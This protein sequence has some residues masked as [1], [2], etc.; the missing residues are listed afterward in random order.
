[1][2]VP[3]ELVIFPSQSPQEQAC[4]WAALLI[5]P[6][7]NTAMLTEGSAEANLSCA[8]PEW[9]HSSIVLASLWPLMPK[10]E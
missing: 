1:M 6:N 3:G 8:L 2:R 4:Q 7:S 5:T 9:G 10:K